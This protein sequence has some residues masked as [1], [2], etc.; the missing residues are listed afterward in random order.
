MLT[1]ENLR[2]GN[3]SCLVTDGESGAANP[4]HPQEKPSRQSSLGTI[5]L[6][7]DFLELEEEHGNLTK[8]CLPIKADAYIRG[9]TE[10]KVLV[11]LKLKDDRGAWHELQVPKAE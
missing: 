7:K 10:P 2:T 3:G 4:K 5:K 11:L 6:K 9:E 1:T 8:V